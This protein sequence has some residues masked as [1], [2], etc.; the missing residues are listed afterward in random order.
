MKV[1]VVLNNFQ[2]WSIIA[3]TTPLIPVPFFSGNLLVVLTFQDKNILCMRIFSLN[4]LN[5]FD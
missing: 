1:T 2:E 3:T 5:Y 4:V